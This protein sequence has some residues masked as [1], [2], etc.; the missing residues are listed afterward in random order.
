MVV[1]YDPQNSES[2]DTTIN[3]LMIT[4]LLVYTKEYE[5]D[6]SSLT[7]TLSLFKVVFYWKP[8]VFRFLWAM[9]EGKEIEGDTF[10]SH[11]RAWG[12]GYFWKDI[13]GHSLL[14]ISAN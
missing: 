8:A 2:W 5:W 3:I 9:E 1:L 12:S 7:E 10:W 4:H 14:V 13:Q 11:Q 6:E